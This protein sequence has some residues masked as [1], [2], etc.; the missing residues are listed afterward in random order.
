M[1]GGKK[2]S[3]HK[4]EL[5]IGLNSSRIQ[6]NSGLGDEEDIALTI[7]WDHHQ[8]AHSWACDAYMYSYSQVMGLYL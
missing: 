2:V 1:L 5:R 8:T 3:I 4:N 6:A 7:R